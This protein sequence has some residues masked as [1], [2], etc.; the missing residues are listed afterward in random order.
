MA[1]GGMQVV[2]MN[3]CR[4]DALTMYNTHH[5]A[6]VVHMAAKLLPVEREKVCTF[7]V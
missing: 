6:S 3:A 7:S 2:C 5:A 1:D 4:R